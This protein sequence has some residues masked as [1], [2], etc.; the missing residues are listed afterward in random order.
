MRINIFNTFVRKYQLG[1][2]FFCISLF[3]LSN[4]AE[5]KNPSIIS[6]ENYVWFA[7]DKGL[8]RY[9]KTQD[10]WDVFS[11]VNGLAGDNIRD[12]GI[13]EGIIWVATDGGISNSDLRYSDWRTYTTSDGIPGNDV[14]CIA[15]SKDYVWIGT[16]KG[17]GRFDKVLEKWKTYTKDDGLSGDEVND[18]VTDAKFAWFATSEGISKLDINFDKWM[19]LEFNVQQTVK[20]S[21]DS[22]D[23]LWFATDNELIRYDKKLSSWKSYVASDGIIGSEINN[24]I[25]DK[26]KL[27][28]ATQDGVRIYDLTSDSWS[29][30]LNYN[31]M[32]PDKNVTDL[33]IDGN[34]IWFCTN[35]GV[36]NYNTETNAWKYYNSS[37][38]LLDNSCKAIAVSGL[39]FVMT[40]KGINIY[41]KSADFW[42][43]YEFSSL[44]TEKLRKGKFLKIDDKGLGIDISEMKFR[45]SGTSSLEFIDS[46]EFGNKRTDIYDSSIKSDLNLKGELSNQRSIIGY[47]NDINKDN[48]EYEINYRG[49]N[50]DILQ[51]IVAGKFPA[52]IRN[53]NIIDDTNLE[54]A[55]GLVR[56]KSDHKQLNFEP[57]YGEQEGYFETDFFIYNVQTSIYQLSHQDII[58]DTDVVMVNDELWQRGS[59]YILI[60]TTGMLMFLREELI[61]EGAK[62][63][64]RYQYR[65]KNRQNKIFLTTSGIDLGN[66]YY[67]GLDVVHNDNFDNISLNGEA[68]DIKI[69]KLSLK[70]NPEFVYSRKPADN[71]DGIAGSLSLLTTTTNAQLKFDHESYSKD[72]ITLNKRETPF[73]RLNNHNEIFSRYDLTNWMP[74]TFKYKQ[75]KSNDGLIDTLERNIKASVAISNPGFPKFIFSGT[76]DTVSSPINDQNNS[77]LRG[78]LQYN[79][80][81][82][83]AEIISYYRVAYQNNTDRKNQTIYTKIK[84]DPIE[85]FNINGSYKLNRL[86]DKKGLKDDYSRL[87]LN[88]N[89]STIKGIINN[90]RFDSF[91]SSE[92]KTSSFTTGLSLL[93]GMWT[94][95]LNLLTFSSIFNASDQSSSNTEGT[96]R[97]RSLRLQTGI[98]PNNSLSL[99]GTYDAIRNRKDRL[100][101]SNRN[102]YRTELEYIP[103]IKSRLTLEYYYDNK[104]ERSLKDFTHSPALSYEQNWSTNWN[105]RFRFNYQYYESNDNTIKKKT[106]FNVS[107]RYTSRKSQNERIYITQSNSLSYDQYKKGI[108]DE[109]YL[110][111]S[112]S[113]GIEWKFSENVSFRNR[114]NLSYTNGNL[115]NGLVNIY[116]RILIKL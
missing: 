27:W 83:N 54:G 47:Y 66:N 115:N 84:L 105:T 76:R 26:D 10:S 73:G 33:A 14:R 28:L 41:D 75:D 87:I 16:D 77:S 68:K 96:N 49:N 36:C 103:N 38:G 19:N 35:N 91:R 104:K 99:T 69:G 42:D 101:F 116:F 62:I 60:Y 97:N 78:D 111:Y 85:K 18:I 25:T 8:Y 81:F 43:K 106:L 61:D 48:V 12:I 59:D 107:F 80:P 45:L 15:F 32:L 109:S 63:E 9:N 7:T 102:K 100:I 30:A 57:R 74:L 67:A 39:V 2:Y 24:F 64:V 82:K 3:Y 20:R 79:L 52:K 40:E 110:T 95:S 90:I 112:P 86:T 13:D 1:I 50:N 17:A 31:V 113:L 55:G 46:S 92:L 98:R 6:S 108:K 5:S 22:R 93:P 58:A 88:S 56:Y 72:F 4:L 23:Y 29:S 71:L 11:K 44:L 114:I 21:V 89:F 34:N 94:N 70:F 51:K 37:N 53:S 65:D